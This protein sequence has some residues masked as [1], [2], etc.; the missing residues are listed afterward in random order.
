M[1]II[2]NADGSCWS[3]FPK[4]DITTMT[5]PL[6]PGGRRC[7]SVEAPTTRLLHPGEGGL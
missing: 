5:T 6:R 1:E 4:V 2:R 3:L 7:E